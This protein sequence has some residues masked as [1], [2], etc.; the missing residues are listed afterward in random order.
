VPE[1]CCSR[2]V[3]V[4]EACRSRELE[5][6]CQDNKCLGRHYSGGAVQGLRG[7]RSIKITEHRYLPTYLAWDP[8]A[9]NIGSTSRIVWAR[10]QMRR[11][12]AAGSVQRAALGQTLA[13]PCETTYA[14]AYAYAPLPSTRRSAW[15]HGRTWA[16]LAPFQ[17]SIQPST[18]TAHAHTRTRSC[19]QWMG[20]WV[21]A[22]MATLAASPPACCPSAAHCAR[23]QASRSLSF[24]GT[25]RSASLSASGWVRYRS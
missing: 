8:Q 9:A 15:N 18:P 2:P 24:S 6:A 20:G 17:H 13:L 12:R 7:R 16:A 4:S 5:G 19:Q 11:Q 3:S 14:Y 25:S 22:C 10:T 1:Q 23:R 21:G